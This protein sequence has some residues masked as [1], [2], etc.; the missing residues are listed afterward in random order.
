MK[1]LISEEPILIHL[2][3]T[4]CLQV[5]LCADSSVQSKWRRARVKTKNPFVVLINT[6]QHKSA[7]ACLKTACGEGRFST[8]LMQCE[9]GVKRAKDKNRPTHKVFRSMRLFLDVP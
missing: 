1:T 5:C 9:L 7:S 6:L 4:V 2:V 3:V 8:F